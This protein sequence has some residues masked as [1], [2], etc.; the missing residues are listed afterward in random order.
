MEDEEI[1]IEA[2]K[3]FFENYK[4]TLPKSLKLYQGS[5]I[6]DVPKFIESTLVI[7]EAQRNNPTYETFKMNLILLK[8]I[9]SPPNQMPDEQV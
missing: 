9:L 1:S 5:T 3:S 6:L 8:N 4:E 2:L 7:V